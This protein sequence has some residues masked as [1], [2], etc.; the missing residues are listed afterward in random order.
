[1]ALLIRETG[2]RPRGFRV[3]LVAISLMLLLQ[4]PENLR[5]R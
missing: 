5:L 1:M 2:H 4:V 3:L